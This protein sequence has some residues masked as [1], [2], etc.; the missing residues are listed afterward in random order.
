MIALTLAEVAAVTGG[1]FHGITAEDAAG[2]VLDGPVVTDS[3]EAGPGS[4]YIARVGEHL[5][6]HAFVAGAAEAGAVA[7]LTSR[8]V[9]ELPCVV[10]GDVQEAFAALSRAVAARGVDLTIVGITGSSGKTST[11]DLLGSVL[12]DLRRDRR[13][14]GVLQL[15]GG[16]PADRHPDHRGH[17]LPRRRDG[18]ARRRPHPLPH[19][20]GAAP[21]RR[22]PQCRERSH[23]RVRQQ[24]GDRRRQGRAR[25]GAARGRGRRPQRRRPDRARDGGPDEGAGRPR[26]RGTRRATCAPRPSASTPAGTPPSTSSRRG[27]PSG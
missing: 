24:G 23:R 10:V 15:R 2:L 14:G 9:D 21:D 26:R 4:L 6:G 18:G 25:R 8:D 13:P 3:R 12:A 16:G 7:A 20:D 11:K 5:D 19:D 1:R 22:G 17:P 27:R